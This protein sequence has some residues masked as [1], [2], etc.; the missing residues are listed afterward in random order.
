MDE[1]K[2]L[3]G[4]VAKRL[5][6]LTEATTHLVTE[7]ETTEDYCHRKNILVVAETEDLDVSG[8]KPI[9]ERPGVGPWLTLDHL[10]EWDVLVLYKLD[11]G[12]RNHRDFVNFYDDFCVTHGKKIVSVTEEIDMSTKMGMFIAGILVQFAEWELT[13]MRERRSDAQ[14][15]IRREARWGGG[16]FSF[17]YQ[18]YKDGFYW[19][20]QPHPVY[21]AETEKMAR[22]VVAG[23]S[24]GNVAKDLNERGIP[25]SRDVQNAWFGR[26]V[27]GYRWDSTAV[28]DHLRS[29]HIRGYVVHYPNDADRKAIRHESAPRR[30][31]G[32]DGEYVRRER[33]IDDDLWYQ[34]QAALDICTRKLSGVR[35]KGSILLR[36]AFCGYC[37]G[38]FYQNSANRSDGNGRNHYYY[39]PACK[40][41]MSVRRELLNETVTGALLDAVGDCELT[42][43]RVI[44]GDDHRQALKKLGMQ[45]ADLTT[46][47]FVN[48]GVDGFHARMAVLEA[49]HERISNLPREKPKIRQVA[50]GKT[51]R[52]HWEEIDDGERHAYLSAAEV[53]ALVV[54]REDFTVTTGE[55]TEVADDLVL[56]I[57]VNIVRVCGKFVV[58]V[59]LGM[60]GDQLQRASET[61]IAAGP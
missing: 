56:D 39:C 4:I 13:R 31:T 24:P 16:S 52:Q 32:P 21:H 45:I 48:G 10:D 40:P 36:I 26:P 29:E 2:Q 33:L 34:V 22:A 18:P 60:L 1:N 6:H 20:L 14:K 43:T 54:R 27:K 9:R 59:S 49:E 28:I 53:S 11:R 61:P 42:E 50:T 8:G 41:C 58:N 46:Q 57:P 37:G 51:F 30:V 3:R 7:S 12:F 35:S 17:G 19:Y 25:T 47:H 38:P 15:V 55:G 44:E 5:S 23:K